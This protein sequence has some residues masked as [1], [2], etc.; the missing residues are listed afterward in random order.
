MGNTEQKQLIVLAVLFL[1]VAVF[2]HRA[3]TT[4]AV[5]KLQMLHKELEKV[6]GHRL[7]SSSEVSR[8]IAEFLELDDY[9]QSTYQGPYGPVSLYIGYYYSLAKLSS[10]HSPLVC[11]PGQGWQLHEQTKRTLQVN[12]SQL[13]YAE[14]VA[15]LGDRQELVLYWYQAGRT[16]VPE[17]YRNKFNALWNRLSGGSQEH[18]FVR[19]TVPFHEGEQELARAA[20]EAFI[21]AFYPAFLTYVELSVEPSAATPL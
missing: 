19:V 7:L 16:T 21:T 1:A 15:R 13:H 3:E 5:Q 12:N 9:V 18:A 14:M 8:E 10:A 4:V 17:V 6:P 11:F 2:V 20:G